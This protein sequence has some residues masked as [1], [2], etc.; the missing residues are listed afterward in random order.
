MHHHFSSR[1]FVNIKNV[2]IFFFSADVVRVD[3]VASEISLYYIIRNLLDKA[4]NSN[5]N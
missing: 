1:I 2:F 5:A 3:A 4:L